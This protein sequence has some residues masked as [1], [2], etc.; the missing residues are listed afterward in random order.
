MEDKTKTDFYKA[1]CGFQAD[2]PIITRDKKTEYGNTK[3]D[4]APF[5]TI[6][7]TIKPHMKK[8]NLSFMVSVE[9]HENSEI[10]YLILSVV[11]MHSSGFVAHTKYPYK[12]IGGGKMNESQANRSA[13]TYAKRSA[14]ENALG[15]ATQGEDDDANRAYANDINKESIDEINKLIKQKSADVEKFLKHMGVEKIE[16]MNEAE[17]RK[18]IAMLRAKS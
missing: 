10:D 7:N 1:L 14:L 3:Y 12:P 13:L 6:V 8:H 17:A 15:L 5:D 16:Y 2:C 4:Y 18:A 11:I 9:P